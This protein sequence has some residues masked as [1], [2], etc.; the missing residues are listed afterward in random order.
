MLT[1]LAL[2]LFRILTTS[3]EDHYSDK[4]K[5]MLDFASI[6]FFWGFVFVFIKIFEF[7]PLTL[8]WA[9]SGVKPM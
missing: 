1:N 2:F 7:R 8:T 4:L 9:S 3:Y 6:K 5:N